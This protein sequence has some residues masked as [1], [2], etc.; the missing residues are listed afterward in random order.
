MTPYDSASLIVKKLQSAGFISYFT[1][2][3]VRDYLMEHPSD[4][5]DI[6]TSAT[7]NQIQSLFEKTIPVGVQFGIIIVSENNHHFEVATFRKES[8][9]EDGRR[10]TQIEIASAKEDAQRRDFTING[11]FFDPLTKEIFDY[12][13]G[14]KDLEKKLIRAIGDAH[15]R[16]LEDRLRMIRAARYA[17]RFHFEIEKETKEAIRAHA[18][19]L[20]PSVAIERVWQEFSKMKKFGGFKHF[21][22]LLFELG[23]LSTIFPDL[24]DLDYKEVA[25]RV[26]VYD[27]F[28]KQTPLVAKLLE[29]FPTYSLEKRILLCERFKLSSEEKNFVKYLSDVESMILA[30]ESSRARLAHSFAK[31]PFLLCAQIIT[32]KFE[33]EK[34]D[35]ILHFYEKKEQKI[36]WAVEKIKNKTP[37]VTS[38]HLKAAGISPGRLMGIFLEEAEKVSIEQHLLDADLIIEILKQDRRWPK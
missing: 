27:F 28:P 8:G 38:N 25:K 24:L 23:L 10:P 22:L 6:A 14:K 5:I 26:Q 4:D 21:L 19:D 3:W 36:S 34:R 1:G 32:A 35:Q 30:S 11:M 9:Y 12:V 13:D 18:K 29:L 17:C 33:K 15:H 37:V 20:F 31:G 7:V 2:G 16:F